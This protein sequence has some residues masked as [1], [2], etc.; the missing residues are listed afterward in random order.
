M[1]EGVGIDQLISVFEGIQD[2][3]LSEVYLILESEFFTLI[4]FETTWNQNRIK[5]YYYL[6]NIGN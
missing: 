1:G 4:A 6:G 5:Y 3:S 2:S